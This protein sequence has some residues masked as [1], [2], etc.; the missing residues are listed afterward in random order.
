MG[1]LAVLAP[2]L[3]LMRARFPT[4]DWVR[5]TMTPRNTRRYS[6]AFALIE[7]GV[8]RAQS[9]SNPAFDTNATVVV[10]LG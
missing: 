10:L 8:S 4:I 1:A 5:D 3:M 9:S 2:S 6:V 7:Q